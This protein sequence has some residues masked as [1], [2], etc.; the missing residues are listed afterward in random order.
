MSLSSAV[1][2]QARGLEFGLSED[3]LA[4]L[5]VK[6]FTTLGA[7]AFSCSVMPGAEGVSP[8]VF[9][10]NLATPIFG[11]TAVTEGHVE[12]PALRRL[13]FEAWMATS[14]D[15]KYRLERK[16][17][18]PARPL[19]RVEREDRR[20]KLD[21]RLR[22]GFC[23]EGANEPAGYLVDEAAGMLEEQVL[24]RIPLERCVSKDEAEGKVKVVSE[25]VP[26]KNG[27]LKMQSQNDTPSM[28]VRG[29]MR[30]QDCLAR[31]AVALDLGNLMTWEA[32]GQ[33]A[34]EILGALKRDPVAGFAPVS[35]EQ[36]LDFDREVWRRLTEE[37]RRKGFRL[38]ADGSRPLDVMLDKVLIE[39]RV[40]MLLLPRAVA[41]V[42]GA[43][44]PA[45]GQQ[46]GREQQLEAKMAALQKQMNQMKGKRDQPPPPP[47]AP[48][49]KAK[50]RA[51]KRQRGPKV[52]EALQG[53]RE[54]TGT[55]QPFCW[56]FNQGGCSNAVKDG[57]CTKGVH[58]CGGCLDPNCAFVSCRR[59][60]FQ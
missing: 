33:L 12:I 23:I 6:G 40:A 4:K 39:P 11:E 14:A 32:H 44:A 7:L 48:G 50:A 52:P 34:K 41:P 35:L 10:A 8:E 19:P 28:P 2:F 46:T 51:N 16:E 27:F 5:K 31:R 1:Y 49:A 24:K 42:A 3:T 9:N 57:R 15:L 25:M 47:A 54:K 58:L 22:P 45:A 21:A 37:T 56:A 43:G 60:A 36:A 13:Y 20:A 38:G 17:D 59:K 26:D 29:L 18:E 55:G 53:M 30:L